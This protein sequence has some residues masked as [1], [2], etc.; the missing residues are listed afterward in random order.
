MA[1]RAPGE[2][3][4][5]TV[6]LHGLYPG[7]WAPTTAT[8]K[9]S[10]AGLR[11]AAVVSDSSTCGRLRLPAVDEDRGGHRAHDVRHEVPAGVGVAADV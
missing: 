10:T 2:P 8:V 11:S 4:R 7:V 6:S 3:S 5:L 1:C 9:S